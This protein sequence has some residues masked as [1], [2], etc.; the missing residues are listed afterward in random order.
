MLID[1]KLKGR[2]VLIF[3]GGIVGERKARNFLQENLRVIVISKRFVRGLKRLSQ[4]GKIELMEFDLKT[5]PS[6]ISSLI[7]D[8]NIVIAA[9]D[10]HKLNEDIAMEARRR[11]VLVSVADKLSISDFYLPA[12]TRF[13]GIRIAVC[14]GGRS[15]AMARILRKRLEKFITREDI[16]QVELQCYARTLA[17][18]SV[19][20]RGVRRSLLYQIIQNPEIKY[21]LKEGNFEEAKD[22]VKQ[23]IERQ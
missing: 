1:L 18:A 4:Q 21:L 7:S 14:T 2:T 9:T 12:T 16:L 19:S 15:P 22:L 5:D 17:K 10:D 20:D 8:S 11:K 6:S 3:G 23:I 13:G